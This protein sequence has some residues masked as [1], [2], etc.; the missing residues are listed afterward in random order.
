M[1]KTISVILLSAVL[2]LAACTTP[3]PEEQATGMVATP[4]AV[5]ARPVIRLTAGG[6]TYT[7]LAGAYCWLQAANDIRCEPDP[8]DL[9]PADVIAVREHE[10]ITFN[11][12]S[13]VGE[14]SRLIFR[15][16]DYP[17]DLGG[18]LEVELPPGPVPTELPYSVDL[19]PGTHRLILVAEYPILDTE[20]GFVS[21]AFS[22][23]VAGAVAAAPTDTPVSEPT[24]RPTL[25]PATEEP[26]ATGEVAA[27][28]EPTATERPAPT[29]TP[30]PTEVPPPT[31]VLATA[32]V[33]PTPAPPSVVPPT[34][35]STP[36][37][38]APEVVLV[39]G[40][41]IIQPYR[42]SFCTIGA[43][44]AQTCS[45]Y[46]AAEGESL[47]A[48]TGDTIRV[49]S[50]E[51]GPRSMA[52]V[53]LDSAGTRELGRMQIPGNPIALYDVLAGPGS[54][55]LRVETVWPQATATYEFRLDVT[56]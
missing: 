25:P 28:V 19:A 18:P 21:Y 10:T 43:D 40:L 36:E 14:A 31:E 13:E 12:D 4:A 35:T 5:P 22:L 50:A 33:P 48:A 17:E 29:S 23:D 46:V 24:E 3:A 7:G 8:L 34:P 42:V 1:N 9:Q 41:A 38:V 53:L 30:K 47:E 16:P 32:T 54:Y 6:A 55:V 37:M 49:D 26:T 52:F 15:L 56:E 11:F 44:G 51:G 20:P 27:V 45:D 39:R 2:I